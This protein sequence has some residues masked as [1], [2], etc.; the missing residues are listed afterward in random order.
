MSRGYW[1]HLS[2]SVCLDLRHSLCH[3]PS[4][5]VSNFKQNYTFPFTSF[6]LFLQLILPLLANHR[7]PERAHRDTHMHCQLVFTHSCMQLPATRRYLKHETLWPVLF[8]RSI[9]IAA[10]RM[11]IKLPSETVCASVHGGHHPAYDA[12]VFSHSCISFLRLLQSLS[13]LQ[14]QM[15]SLLFGTDERKGWNTS[16][17]YV[18]VH[19]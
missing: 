17:Y 3:S 8:I 1:T 15:C 16:N 18:Q 11:S 19:K 14:M 10:P 9:E 5:A 12:R 6:F 2:L 4:V 13:Y 7:R